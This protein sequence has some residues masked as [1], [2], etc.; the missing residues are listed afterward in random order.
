LFLHGGAVPVSGNMGFKINGISWMTAMAEKGY[1]TWGLDFAGYGYSGRFDESDSLDANSM[2]Q[3][4]VIERSKQTDIAI[5]FILN[6]R[7]VKNIDLLGNSGG[8]IVAGLYATQFPDKIKKLVLHGP[9]TKETKGADTTVKLTAYDYVNPVELVDLFCGWK[10]AGYEPVLDRKYLIDY[11]VPLYL[12]SDSTSSS[13]SPKTL[14]IPGGVTADPVE[15]AKGKF[16]YDPEKI[17]AP[18]LITR[19]KMGCCSY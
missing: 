5:N 16:P 4:N 7:K 15:I 3:G 17:T 10:P 1:D 11:F 18:T 9:I 2:P 14:K 13:R 12:K 6:K 8:S 19:G